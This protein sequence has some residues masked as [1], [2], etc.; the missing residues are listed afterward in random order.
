M[1]IHVSLG[2]ITREYVM[3]DDLYTYT[4]STPVSKGDTVVWMDEDDL[5][6]KAEVMECMA[7]QFL[8]AISTGKVT[9]H[10][11]CFYSDKGYRWNEWNKEWAAIIAEKV[12]AAKAARD[13]EKGRSNEEQEE[14]QQEG[15]A[16]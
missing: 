6:Y 7:S 9:H 10:R 3:S 5:P 4:G 8:V 15:E 16:S 11:Y 2:L 14:V 13:N 1:R 12:E